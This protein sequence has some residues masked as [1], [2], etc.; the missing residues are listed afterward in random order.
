[1]MK[2]QNSLEKKG[3]TYGFASFGVKIGLIASSSQ[4]LNDMKAVVDYLPLNPSEISYE[5]AEFHFSIDFFDGQYKFEKD[6]EEICVSSDKIH[7][8]K[9]LEN[10]LRITVAEFAVSNV[11]IHA[12]AVSI[13]NKGIIFPAKSF[14]G[15]STLTAELVKK[16]ATYYSD[17]YTILDE[18][19]YLNPFAKNL[20]MRGITGE[21]NQV[22]LPVEHFGGIKGIDSVEIKLVVLTEYEKGFKWSPE[23]LSPGNAIM[24]LLPHT[25]PIRFN[26]KFTLE[27]LHKLVNRAI[28]T[29]SKR[30]DFE[31]FIPQLLEFSKKIDF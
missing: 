31:E 25:I 9:F 14:Q 8:F 2:S 7:I 28:I 20:S 26:P 22:D 30:G 24:E 4:I 29:K 21:Y 27:V 23:I 19:A 17:D 6:E 11:F 3:L 5:D 10:K 1:M 16:G 13:N 12:G 15:K 18:N